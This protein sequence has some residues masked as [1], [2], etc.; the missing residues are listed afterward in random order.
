MK[1]SRVIPKHTKTVHF[2][3]CQK[4]WI[5][6]SEKF[7]K[8]R[9]RMRN[10]LDTCFWCGHNFKDGE[11]MSIAQPERGANKVLCNGCADKLL[12]SG[13]SSDCAVVGD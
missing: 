10:K 5:E 13:P 8:I 7:R 9:S 4:D 3:W 12:S 1:L 11:K 2:N 6:M